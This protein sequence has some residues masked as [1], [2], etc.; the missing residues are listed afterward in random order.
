[1]QPISRQLS[2]KN[3]KYTEKATYD[4]SYPS[5]V[6]LTSLLEGCHQ[7]LLEEKHSITRNNE[8]LSV[9]FLLPR[10]AHKNTPFDWTIALFH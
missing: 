1:M 8:A 7:A 9:F 10:N 3:S 6:F 4:T 5:L 2:G